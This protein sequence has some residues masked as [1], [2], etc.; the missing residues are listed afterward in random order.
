MKG[1]TLRSLVGLVVFILVA[2]G[3]YAGSE[4]TESEK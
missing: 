4:S 2:F 1:I 3:A